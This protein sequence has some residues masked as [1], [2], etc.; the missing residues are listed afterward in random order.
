[1]PKLH[2]VLKGLI[3]LSLL[4]LAYIIIIPGGWENRGFPLAIIYLTT[5]ILAIWLLNVN[6]KFNS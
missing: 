6:R 2:P 3:I 5:I 1:M 4:S